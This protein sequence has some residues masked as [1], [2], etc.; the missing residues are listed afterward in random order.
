[1]TRETP[2]TFSLGG[3]CGGI[4]LDEKFLELMKTKVGPGIWGKVTKTETT[5]LLNDD[6]E[7]GIKRQF[8]NQDRSWLITLPE[9]CQD[10][11]RNG[12][13]K[14][15]TKRKRDMTLSS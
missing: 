15:G 4:F 13:S 12:T 3:L 5:K 11:D 6:W 10:Y 9:S 1:L 8:Q 7:H 14:V 2:L